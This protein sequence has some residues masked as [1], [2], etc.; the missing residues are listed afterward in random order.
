MTIPDDLPARVSGVAIDGDTAAAA[1]AAGG[2]DVVHADGR[3]TL[4]PPSWRFD[5]N[6]PY[7]L[8]EDVL[9]VVGYDQVPSVLPPAP[10]GRGLTTAQVLRRRVGMV[11]AGAGLVE[12]K[13]FPFAGPA[14]LR[15]ARAARRRRSVAA[16]C[17]SRTP[18][19]PSSRA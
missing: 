16:R 14:G 6:D 1:L 8:V 4:T 10:A 3:I 19:R 9:R 2:G 18:C 11:L 5:L 15:P 7:D 13:T 12:V 17:C